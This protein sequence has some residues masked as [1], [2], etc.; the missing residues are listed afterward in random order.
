MKRCPRLKI[1]LNRSLLSYILEK[2]LFCGD[3][4][5]NDKIAIEESKR[6]RCEVYTRV[7]GYFRPVSHYNVGKKSEHRERMF[8]KEIPLPE[9]GKRKAAQPKP[10][11]NYRDFVMKNT[12][13]ICKPTRMNKPTQTP[14]TPPPPPHPGKIESRLSVGG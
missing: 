13:I 9:Q 11:L 10:R 14:T 8:F 6:Q 5:M 4:K 2:Y 1:L 12:K 3:I 7:M